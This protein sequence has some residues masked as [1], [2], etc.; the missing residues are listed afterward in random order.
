MVLASSAFAVSER[1]SSMYS[2][3]GLMTCQVQRWDEPAA[4]VC[5]PGRGGSE[6]A[7]RGGSSAGGPVSDVSFFPLGHA[8]ELGSSPDL[9]AA[10]LGGLKPR[11]TYCRNDCS[12]TFNECAA[13][14]L[15]R[16]EPD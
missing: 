12:G 2:N 14:R 3:M 16:I 7:A 9:P 1:Q 10:E 6:A 11:G 15:E 4:V 5:V 13:D 8:L